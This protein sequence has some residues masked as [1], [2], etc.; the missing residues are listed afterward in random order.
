MCT[1]T[2]AAVCGPIGLATEAGSM[3]IVAGSQST[4]RGVAPA[5]MTAAAV[6]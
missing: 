2:T 3:A 4:K 6:A 5:A 1:T